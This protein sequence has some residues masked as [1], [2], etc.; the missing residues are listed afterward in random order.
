MRSGVGSAGGL[1]V[2]RV[3]LRSTHSHV[4]LCR[5]ILLSRS[6]LDF[7]RWVLVGRT[8]VYKLLSPLLAKLQNTRPQLR[9][10][11]VLLPQS[12]SQQTFAYD[13]HEYTSFYNP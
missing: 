2:Y 11:N 12:R 3:A 7:L 5:S 4:R 1:V 6:L 10:I 13:T 8:I 9:D